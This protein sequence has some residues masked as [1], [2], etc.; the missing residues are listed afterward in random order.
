M[1]CL[2]LEFYLSL[3]LS[4]NG[5]P[6]SC[7]PT[8]I[9]HALV[10]QMI[11]IIVLSHQ[12]MTTFDISMTCPTLFA[13]C[14]Y[15][16]SKTPTEFFPSK[17]EKCSHGSVKL[18]PGLGRFSPWAGGF[19]PSSDVTGEVPT[20]YPIWVGGFPDR[21]SISLAD[22]GSRV[23]LSW[24]SSFPPHHA[25]PPGFPWVLPPIKSFQEDAH[26]WE[27]PP[28]LSRGPTTCISFIFFICII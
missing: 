16:F 27:I 21:L 24:E 19:S 13:N 6:P 15:D 22:Q 14:P 28:R 7:F 18:E 5:R 20:T 8:I 23:L 26:S 1:P 11:R 3:D 25:A 17:R 4:G 12:I 10:E 9:R 2:L